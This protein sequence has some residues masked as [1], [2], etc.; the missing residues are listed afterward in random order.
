[1]ILECSYLCFNLAL[2]IFV[3]ANAL[4]QPEVWHIKRVRLLLFEVDHNLDWAVPKDHGAVSM[5]RMRARCGEVLA[6]Y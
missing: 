6:N 2:D 4:N 3:G 1:M 5:K